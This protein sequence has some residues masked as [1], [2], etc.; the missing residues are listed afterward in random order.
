MLTVNRWPLRPV[1]I[2][3]NSFGPNFYQKIEWACKKYMF[4]CP[5]S[6]LNILTTL[7]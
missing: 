2:P 4:T 6:L 1:K 7:I 5:D 3:P